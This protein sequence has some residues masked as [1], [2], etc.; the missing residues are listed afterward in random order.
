MNATKRSQDKIARPRPRR[1]TRVNQTKSLAEKI[2]VHKRIAKGSARKLLQTPAASFITIFVVA[3]SLLLPA[4]LFSLNSNLA[5]LLAGFAHSA[6][7]TL[8]L[9][10]DI[11]ETNGLE[12]SNNLLTRDDIGAAYYV[13]PDQ[14]LDEFGAATGLESLLQEIARNPLPGAIIL[15]PSDV[16]PTAVDALVAELQQIDA[17]DLVQV[18]S[19][20][21][22]RLAAISNLVTIITRVLSVI[23]ILGLFFVVGNTIKLAVENRKAEIRVIKLVGGSDMFAARPFLYS[24]LFYGLAGGMLATVLQLIV[25]FAFNSSLVALTQLYESNFQLQG[26]G[27]YNGLLLIIAGG[28]IGWTA[29]LLASLRHIRGISP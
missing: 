19:R 4:L 28:L 20:W 15:T 18:D 8:Y 23:V 6:Q 17:V 13:S 10:D 14:A 2:E 26:F 27:L 24:G 16:S 29:S 22:Q 3:V 7:V 25:F 5:S 1:N 12:V 9:R 21:L 11:S